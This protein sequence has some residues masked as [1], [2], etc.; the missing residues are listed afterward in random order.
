MSTTSRPSADPV[1]ISPTHPL[2]NSYSNTN[3]QTQPVKDEPQTTAFTTLAS[4][5]ACETELSTSRPQVSNVSSQLSTRKPTTKNSQAGPT[6]VP[7]EQRGRTPS[8]IPSLLSRISSAAAE[9]AVIAVNPSRSFRQLS[10]RASTRNSTRSA[11][12]EPSPQQLPRDGPGDQATISVDVLPQTLWNPHSVSP[13]HSHALS[14]SPP[15]TTSAPSRKSSGV[16]KPSDDDQRQERARRAS[17]ASSAQRSEPNSRT[18]ST[19]EKE[20]K[21]HQTSSRLLR[22]TDDDRPFTRVSCVCSIFNIHPSP[23]HFLCTDESVFL[24]LPLTG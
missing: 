3:E 1:E 5:N 22:M 15:S 13:S 9:G 17:F 14:T 11:G 19:V 21:M 6:A 23:P 8:R 2:T 24:T 16:Y 12:I 10:R 4:S 7:R 20:R 18:E